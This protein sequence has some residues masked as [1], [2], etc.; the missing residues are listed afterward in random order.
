MGCD[1]SPVTFVRPAGW[2]RLTEHI[3]H[4]TKLEPAKAQRIFDE[5][6]ESVG[7]PVR[8]APVICAL[9]RTPPFAL[10]CEAFDECDIKSERI[11]GV[12]MRM[13]ERASLIF[14]DGHTGEPDYRRLKGEPQPESENIAVR[15][16]AGD[17]IGF[18]FNLI[19]RP[20]YGRLTACGDGVPELFCDGV[21][22]TC[23]CVENG[24]Y[25]FTINGRNG[26]G[27]ATLTVRCAEG[28]L[29]ADVLEF[30]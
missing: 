21:P 23:V 11:P 29:D 25:E 18:S 24:K 16:S 3:L 17:S 13:R 27:K 26:Q 7:T 6:L 30:R 22:L 28:T 20:V 9:T 2:D 8:N 19:K 10:P 15:L 1:N 14:C 12:R 4:G 5:F